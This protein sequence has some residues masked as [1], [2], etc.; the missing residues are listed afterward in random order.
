MKKG[1]WDDSSDDESA[2]VDKE[3]ENVKRMKKT[4]DKNDDEGSVRSIPSNVDE[5]ITE[6]SISEQNLIVQENDEYNESILI[7]KCDVELNNNNDPAVA[8]S[9][10]DNH[11]TAE[12]VQQIENPNISK[13]N[14][15]I[16][17]CRSVD[18]YERINFISQGTYGVVFKAKSKETGELVALKQVKL[19]DEVR[20]VGFPITAL[21]ETN[22]LLALSHPNIIRVHEMVVGSSIDKIFMVMDFYDNDLKSCMDIKKQPFSNAEV[23][24]AID[25]FTSLLQCERQ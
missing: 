7:N 21:R 2:G 15:L 1:R 25:H 23:R 12:P 14:P 22:I 4:D 13:H 9:D 8:G 18:C 3:V 5:M 6:N 24:P 20:R 10:S 11:E 16:H 17:G 19:G